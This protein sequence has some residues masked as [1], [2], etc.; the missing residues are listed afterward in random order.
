MSGVAVAFVENRR[1]WPA[2]APRL[3][4]NRPGYPTAPRHVAMV[5]N[6]PNVGIQKPCKAQVDTKEA[7]S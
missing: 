7:R 6:G 5:Y 1:R 3:S 2:I 4:L